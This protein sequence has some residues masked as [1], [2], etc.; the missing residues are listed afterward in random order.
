MYLR[1]KSIRMME[2]TTKK[3]KMTKVHSKVMTDV[4]GRIH[5]EAAKGRIKEGVGVDENHNETKDIIKLIILLKVYVD[6]LCCHQFQRGSLLK[7]ILQI[8][9]CH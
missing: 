7:I 5:L 1:R 4:R 8:V 6:M 3:E 9:C 2:S